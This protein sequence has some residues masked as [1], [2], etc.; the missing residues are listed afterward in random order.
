[1]YLWS[2]IGEVMP[3]VWYICF[4]ALNTVPSLFNNVAYIHGK[5]YMDENMKYCTTKFIMKVSVNVM[6]LASFHHAVFP[7]AEFVACNIWLLFCCCC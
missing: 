3:G 1:M 4:T 2:I 5:L 7:C 6:N